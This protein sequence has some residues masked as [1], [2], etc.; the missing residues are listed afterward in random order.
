MQAIIVL[1]FGLFVDYGDE[2]GPEVSN[3]TEHIKSEEL[4]RYYPS[5][6][7]VSAIFT[8]YAL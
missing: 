2:V 8:A 7:P 4:D 1:L 6:F 5:K 3:S